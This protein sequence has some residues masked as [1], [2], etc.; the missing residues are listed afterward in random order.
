V[1]LILVNGFGE[2]DVEL[3]VE[4]TG[5]VVSLRGHSLAM[6]DFQVTVVDDLARENI[7]D[8]STV[9][10]MADGKGTTSEGL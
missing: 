1:K 3:D 6:N 10:Q 9:V 8:K 7:D 2:L 5:F 4:V